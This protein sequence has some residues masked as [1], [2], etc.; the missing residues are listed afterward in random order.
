MSAYTY[1]FS[2]RATMTALL[3]S[4]VTGCT[5]THD[6]VEPAL[7]VGQVNGSSTMV[8][9]VDGRP[10]V[11]HNYADLGTI[12]ISF[13]GDTRGVSG[14]LS[15]D[16][17]LTI[18]AADS[19]N[20]SKPGFQNHVLEL[21]IPNFRSSGSYRLNAAGSRYPR[22]AYQTITQTQAPQTLGNDPAFY[23]VPAT[24]P[25]VV[26]RFWNPVT[27]HIKGTVNITVIARPEAPITGS[28]LPN[29]SRAEVPA[30]GAATRA[31]AAW[32]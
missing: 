13:I 3:L 26:V 24:A 11:A 17:A 32:Q 28:K 21:V 27:R 18:R 9:R 2:R 15:A 19:Q 25:E 22:T 5:L 14:K 31:A 10:V 20:F 23:P 1:D 6:D 30:V 29:P 4:L 7:P 12:L 16:T 8:Y